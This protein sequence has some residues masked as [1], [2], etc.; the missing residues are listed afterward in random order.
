MVYASMKNNFIISLNY[1]FQDKSFCYFVM[2]YAKGGD[3]YS[4]INNPK[5]PAKV[6]MYR[7][8]G[9]EGARFILACVILGLEC[10]HSHNIIYRDLKP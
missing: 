7:Q 3:V 10:A 4:L 2:E 8:L 6:K 5:Q 9:E 1:A